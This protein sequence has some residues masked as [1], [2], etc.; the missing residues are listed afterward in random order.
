MN[1]NDLI[2]ISVKYGEYSIIAE[3]PNEDFNT[4][5]EIILDALKQCLNSIII[6]E[7]EY[8][9]PLPKEQTKKAMEPTRD[10]FKIRERIPNNVVDVRTLNVKQ[11]ITEKA[12]VRCPHCG[13]SH[14]LAMVSGSNVYMMRK[15]Y[16]ATGNDD[17]FRT[18]AEFDST[19]NKAFFNMCCKTETDKKAYFEDIQ[20]IGMLD[21][22]DFTVTNDT[23]IFCPVC[24]Q[25]D[26]FLNW[27]DAYEYPLNYFETEHLCDVCGGET[28][29]KMVKKQKVCKCEIC[30]HETKY[31][32]E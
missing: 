29:T 19:K 18:I 1:K 7:K 13:Q 17:E 5:T 15:F 23:E 12:L 20:K 14:V 2:T 27:K 32:E 10:E 8:I 25:S 6:G 11:A 9:E 16:S 30:G 31:K 26:V 21:D 28:V 22:K 3:I 4:K 24:C